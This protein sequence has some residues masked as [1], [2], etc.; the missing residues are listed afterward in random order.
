MIN[1]FFSNQKKA[2]RAPVDFREADVGLKRKEALDEARR[3]PQCHDARCR[4]ACPLGIDIPDFIRMIRE[5]DFNAAWAKIKDH[6]EFPGICGR[7]CLAPC[8]HSC[9]LKTD[10]QPIAIR[11]LERFAADHGQ[12]KFTFSHK[13]EL[14]GSKVA[15]VGS[16]PSGLSAAA[17]LAKKGYLVTVFEAFPHCGGIF[18]YGIPRFRLP[19]AALEVEIR[20]V[21]SRGIKIEN[22]CLLGAETQLNEL[23]PLGFS[24][25]LLA[26]GMG[27]PDFTDLPG[28]NF[29][30]V[31][32]AME[33]LMR[34][35]FYNAQARTKDG[36]VEIGQRVA[37][38]GANSAALDCARICIRLKKEA[39]LIFEKTEEDLDVY[40]QE[41]KYA[42]SEGVRFEAMTRPLRIIAGPDQGVAGIEC[43]HM[44]Y[45]DPD[46][47]GK[48]RLVPVPK[49]ETT[50]EVD[51]VIVVK[52]HRP[53][54][55]I[56]KGIGQ[57]KTDSKGHLW[58][59]ERMMTSQKGVFAVGECAAVTGS[60]VN[61]MASGKKAAYG[62]DRYLSEK[63]GT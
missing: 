11:A 54:T 59:D 56:L 50:I 30:R 35:N 45:A 61:A 33:F 6:N 29:A 14:I 3:C 41:K 53:N 60:V 25:I 43:I 55:M 62:I 58:V 36:A 26:V 31:Y 13:P 47:D 63:R 7:T 16:G 32:Y 46:G 2:H 57:L 18:Y 9:I 42:Q 22:H 51:S 28:A 48:W 39:I 27:Q 40:P 21:F 38:L 15:V 24:A 10:G 44:D 49:S 5:G 37:I 8:E 19:I 12:E 1:K 4:Q 23:W 17:T 34:S 52:G 20:Q